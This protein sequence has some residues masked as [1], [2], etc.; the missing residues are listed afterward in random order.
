M[1]QGE[2]INKPKVSIIIPVYNTGAYVEEAVRSIM[3]QT[4]RE[5]E[6]IIIDDGST[7]NSL[8]VVEKL[9]REDNRIQ[10]F[11]QINQGQSVARNMGIKKAMGKYLYF[12]DSDDFLSAEALEQCYLKSE[13]LKTDFILFNAQVLNK[14]N[15]FGISYDYKP[16]ALE[17][18]RTYSGEEILTLMLNQRSYRC[19]PCIHFIRFEA[20]ELFN[21]RFFPGIIHEDELFTALLYLQ[22][23]G[24]GYINNAFFKRRFRGDSV[25]TRRYSIKN[26]N[27][28]L[29]VVDQLRNFSNRDNSKSTF[30]VN[31][32]VKYILDPNI[33]KANTLPFKD[34]IFIFKHCLDKGYLK[35][36]SLKSVVVLLFPLAIQIKGLFKK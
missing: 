5:I 22:A 12:M 35:Y 19:S 4:L 3:N 8:S 1:D 16:P 20:I 13:E 32:L 21:I 2:Q 30:L 25:M 11:S 15:E 24:A 34:R 28:Y 18:D 29:V 31:R 9:A 33:Y 36:L 26:V 7:D 6:I 14:Q 17:E 23:S 10:Y 27:S